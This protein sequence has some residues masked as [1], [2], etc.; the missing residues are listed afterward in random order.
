VR[1][2]E[3]Y[4]DE[5]VRLGPPEFR[6]ELGRPVLVG[7]GII[8]ELQD[9]SRGRTGT[10][11][12]QPA[13]TSM[14]SQS[15]VG[16]I[17][18]VTKGQNGPRGPQISG[19]R[20]S[21]NDIVLPEFTISN[22]HFHFRYDANRLVVIDLG[23]TNG[24]YVNDVTV[25]EKALADGDQIKIGRSIFKFIYGGNIELSYH[26]EIYRL[27]TF[28]GLTQIHNKR[29]FDGAL[30]REISRSQRYKR[31]LSLVIFD[32][33]HFKKIND[34]RGH[35]AGDA[36]LRQ[37][38]SLVSQNIR[39]E[40]LF[41][42]VGGE[43]FA[44]LAPEIALEGARAVAEKLRSVIESTRCRFEE[45]EIKITSSFGVACHD[46]E[47]KLTPQELYSAADARLYLAKNGGRNRVM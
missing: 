21:S 12:M 15:L 14:P 44:L 4:A 30:E 1:T 27:M 7:L 47:A 40:D 10:L 2:I 29:A 8:G 37:L 34:A 38:A 36:V 23:S 26:E 20:A 31:V 41:A 9:N 35:L 24:T 43:E 6:R 32:I 45:Q 5:Y 16:R 25:R 22:H 46:P 28:D 39:R 19:G 17:W 33:D 18:L 11:R 3:Q 13:S 42:R